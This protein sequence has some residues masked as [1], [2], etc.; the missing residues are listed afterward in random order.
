MPGADTVTE[1]GDLLGRRPAI[2]M[3]AI[4]KSFSGN[5]VLDGVDFELLPGEVHVL[6]GGNGAGTSTLMKIL[7]GV[8]SMDSGSIEIDGLPVSIGSIHEARA[9]GDRKSVV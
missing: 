1:P 3:S 5:V 9:A 2:A 4:R 6:A 7:Q 8:Y